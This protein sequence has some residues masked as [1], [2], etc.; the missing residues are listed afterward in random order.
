MDSDTANLAKSTF[1][2]I[3]DVLEVLAFAA[4]TILGVLGFFVLYQLKL[5]KDSLVTARQSLESTNEDMQTRIKR[6][7][8]VLTAMQVE[9]FGCQMA[10]RMTS[11]MMAYEAAKM[12]LLPWKLN[13]KAF[14]RTSIDVEAADRWLD[15]RRCSFLI[16]GPV[17]ARI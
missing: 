6:E 15:A 12:P 1:T 10:P 3:R 8:V 4:T 2:N 13:N 16:T 9:R 11:A 17:S 5:A 7:A 14:D